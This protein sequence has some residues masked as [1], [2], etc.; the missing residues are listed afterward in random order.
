MFSFFFFLNQK[1]SFITVIIDVTESSTS[2]GFERGGYHFPPKI[3]SQHA[4][5]KVLMQEKGKL[6]MKDLREGL[7]R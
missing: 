4:V 7:L 3:H 5:S 6:R 1:L 2:S